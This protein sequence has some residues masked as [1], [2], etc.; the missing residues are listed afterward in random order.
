MARVEAITSDALV[1]MELRFIITEADA[2]R[3]RAFYE[4]WASSPLVERRLQRNVH[5][6]RPTVN[7]SGFW[8]AMVNCLLST[9]QRSGPGSTLEQFIRNK[10]YP[11]P[12]EDCCGRKDL[13]AHAKSTFASFRIASIPRAVPSPSFRK[14]SR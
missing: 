3:A 1:T 14:K 8:F 11:L 9:Q 13:A 7:E 4:K 10:P 6:K 12:F 2:G 5:G